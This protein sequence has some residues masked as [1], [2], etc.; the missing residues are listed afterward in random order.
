MRNVYLIEE[1]AAIREPLAVCLRMAGFEVTPCA[2]AIQALALIPKR[3][4]DLI[5]LDL[6][7]PRSNGLN[8]LGIARSRFKLEETPVVVLS[9]TAD[10]RLVEAAKRLGCRD[11]LLK[12]SFSLKELI[13]ILRKY[14]GGAAVVGPATAAGATA[15][16]PTA[17]PEPI[18]TCPP[19][20]TVQV[21][22]RQPDA[23]TLPLLTREQ[24]LQ[25]AKES[26][27]DKTLGG[28]VA[29]VIA[30][31]TSPRGDLAQLASVIGRDPVLSAR[32][33]QVANSAAYVS[34]KGGCANIAEA[35]RLLGCTTVRNLAVTMGV[36]DAMPVTERDGFNPMRS[37]QHSFAV[38]Q[39]CER[40]LGEGHEKSAVAYLVGLCHDLGEILFRT[41]FAAE[42]EKVLEV[43]LKTGQPREQ[44]EAKLLGMTHNE[45]MTT[46]VQCMRLP[47]SII[48]PVEEFHRAGAGPMRDPIARVL[49]LA[50]LYANA[51]LLAST[52]ASMV[53]PLT[54]SE[55]RSAIK[56]ANPG[57][58]QAAHFRNEIIALTCM[59]ARLSAA[60]AREIAQPILAKAPARVWLARDPGLTRLDPLSLALAELADVGTY[61][62]LPASCQRDQYDVLVVVAR[63]ANAGGFTPLEIRPCVQEASQLLW[64][65]A[66]GDDAGKTEPRP[67]RWNISL[68][69][70]GG[71][72]A[73]RQASKS[74]APLA[75]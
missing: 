57:V 1:I 15:P 71:F 2:D 32:V 49:R 61:D 43:S 12:S 73:A 67:R 66:P 42:Y 33:L 70:L 24:C 28:E 68:A 45:L 46:I 72:L 69:D 48:A 40:F 56:E 21:V 60:E 25:R 7:A 3:R 75:A 36:F 65:T 20:P 31:S 62:H 13:S 39:L 14:L 22:D 8:F 23:D 64:L 9:A 74:T 19:E 37:W 17:A 18:D 47:E 16:A 54:Q 34:A 5:V 11:Y 29:E 53:S 44:V 41:R 4:P 38:A 50:D 26:L 10:R 6:A 63:S 52:P 27:A 59:L 51:M 30:I 58:P 35:V 55:C